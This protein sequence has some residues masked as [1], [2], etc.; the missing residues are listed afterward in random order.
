MNRHLLRIALTSIAAVAIVMP[1]GAQQRGGTARSVQ[2]R[3]GP[4]DTSPRPQA[5]SVSL[6]LGEMQ[7]SGGSDNVPVAA[8]KALT[9]VKDFLPY[10]AYRLLDSQWTL[11]C[12]R[13]SMV[14][15]PIVSRLRGPEEQDYSVEIVPSNAG[16]GKYYVHFSLWEPRITETAVSAGGRGAAAS[17]EAQRAGETPQVQQMHRDQLELQRVQ[18]EQQLAEMRKTLSENHPD[19]AV[20][21]TRIES[22]ERSLNELRRTEPMRRA[23][24][25]SMPRRP[26]IDTS[27]TMDIGETVVVGT[28]RLKGD[29]ALIALLTAVAPTK[30]QAK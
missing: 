28:S 5:F 29:K 2:A 26:I 7:A 13:S 23:L 1:L 10:K 20:A 25:A 27:F 24:T 19:I 11:C 22:L 6:V 17:L 14:S 4:Y 9:D 3:E 12:G 15:T 21:K 30:A 16:N 8:R 18:L